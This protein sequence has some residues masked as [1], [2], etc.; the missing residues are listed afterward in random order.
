M[1]QLRFVALAAAIVMIA[2]CGGSGSS[3]G[4]LNT[5]PG[6][7]PTPTPTPTPS[8]N[9]VTLAN[10]AFNPP[11]LNVSAG[12]TVTWNWNDCSDT[13]G[14]GGYGTCVSHSVV[15]DDGSGI[16]SIVQG[17]GS[18][19]RT[20]TTAGTYNYHCGIHGAAMTG[21]IIVS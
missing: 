5:G 6:P 2:A 9:T 8:P 4:N 17:Q 15:F 10:L 18:F 13:G 3:G 16:S 20:F 12:T 21:K 11:S 7:N 14:Y 19:T 1:R